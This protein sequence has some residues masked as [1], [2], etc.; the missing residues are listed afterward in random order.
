VN[1]FIGVSHFHFRNFISDGNTQSISTKYPAL[2]LGGVARFGL[3][4]RPF[5]PAREIPALCGDWLYPAVYS[6]GE[7][8]ADPCNH[9][10]SIILKV[11][12]MK[13]IKI[14]SLIILICLLPLVLSANWSSTKGYF[15]F[16]KD[17]E[18]DLSDY[19]HA[20]AAVYYRGQIFH[21]VNYYWGKRSS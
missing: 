16:K 8:G 10:I 11:K 21:F 12:I 20:S 7:Y 17:I 14:Y 4:C 2:T 19:S 18:K 5:I 6:Y 1:A 13:T 3:G 15:D 9:L